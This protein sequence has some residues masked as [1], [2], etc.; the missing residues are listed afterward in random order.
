MNTIDVPANLAAFGDASTAWRD[1]G[2]S[3]RLALLD[4]LDDG[5]PASRAGLGR[6]ALAFA[7]DRV[8]QLTARDEGG[9]FAADARQLAQDL[10]AVL[11]A[12]PLDVAALRA[13]VARVEAIAADPMRRREEVGDA[14]WCF[15]VRPLHALAGVAE[16][17]LAPRESLA[18]RA[19]SI[20]GDLA[21]SEDFGAGALDRIERDLSR[22]L[23]ASRPD[24]SRFT[25]PASRPWW[26]GL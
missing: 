23:D 10:G 2:L 24:L 13:L 26:A 5:Q 22:A 3:V 7:A 9:L 16:L 1:G 20:I 18:A 14:V 12:A 11:R 15:S 19:R 8:H 6:A 17:V 21:N 25:A 4:A